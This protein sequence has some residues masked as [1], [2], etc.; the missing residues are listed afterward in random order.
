MRKVLPARAGRC[1][2][3]RIGAP[4]PTSS[5]AATESGTGARM[6]VGSSA[7]AAC[8]RSLALARA[9]AGRCHCRLRSQLPRGPGLSCRQPHGLHEGS[10]HSTRVRPSMIGPPR[11]FC[12]RPRR[13]GVTVSPQPGASVA[14]IDGDALSPVPPP[15]GGI[16]ARGLGREEIPRS[17]LEAMPTAA[18][19]R[20]YSPVAS[21]M[22]CS[23]ALVSGCRPDAPTA[24][25]GAGRLPSAN[26]SAAPSSNRAQSSRQ[27]VEVRRLGPR[28][29]RP[30]NVTED[31]NLFL[32]LSQ[33]VAI[34]ASGHSVI[35]S[36]VSQRCRDV[37]H[38]RGGV[39]RVGLRN[40]GPCW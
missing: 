28:L 5:K 6:T 8:G 23:L 24:P 39:T 38:K 3:K 25:L 33:Y 1:W 36:R 12:R 15:R 20:V 22:G 34:A 11:C 13:T 35:E 26:P 37:E 16:S 9:G 18:R 30:R 7:S 10:R 21:P 40:G 32:R 27:P 19:Q 14:A 17:I 2:R 29:A 31:C 4:T